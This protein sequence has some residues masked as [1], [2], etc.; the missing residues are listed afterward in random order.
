MERIKRAASTEEIVKA[1][2]QGGFDFNE[3]GWAK[4]HRPRILAIALVKST[5]VFRRASKRDVWLGRLVRAACKEGT[6]WGLGTRQREKAE[7]ESQSHA[8]ETLQ[9]IIRASV[10]GGARLRRRR[11]L[12]TRRALTLA[13]AARPHRREGQ[14]EEGPFPPA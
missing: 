10:G 2:E 14:K 6:K 13:S 5:A 7:R 4:G 11:R 3:Q 1:L 12:M 8:K 9:E